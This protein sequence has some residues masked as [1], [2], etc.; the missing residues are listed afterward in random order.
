MFPLF[1][2]AI[3]HSEIV[4]AALQ[5][6]KTSMLRFAVQ[7]GYEKRHGKL[8]EIS[9][10]GYDQHYTSDKACIWGRP[11]GRVIVNRGTAVLHR[12]SWL[13]TRQ[14]VTWLFF[15]GVQWIW[16]V[17]G[18]SPP[19]PAPHVSTEH[20]S[21]SVSTGT[22]SRHVSVWYLVSHLLFSALYYM[23]LL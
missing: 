22:L 19:D 2:A 16:R 4:N 1:F 14:V 17:H 6:F 3:Y 21:T 13:E 15:A 8:G 10:L 5:K 23:V 20:V 12:H 9:K 18:L 11:K 7:F